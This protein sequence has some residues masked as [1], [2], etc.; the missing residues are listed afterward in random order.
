MQYNFFNIDMKQSA[1]LNIL[2]H[3]SHFKSGMFLINSMKIS[4]FIMYV[5]WLHE[6]DSARKDVFHICPHESIAIFAM[7]LN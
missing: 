7:L 5:K 2:E 6:R 3:N 4:Y 1:V